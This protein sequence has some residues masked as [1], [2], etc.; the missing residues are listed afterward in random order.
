M[1]LRIPVVLIFRDP[2]H[3]QEQHQYAQLHF[4]EKI[5]Q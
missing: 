2:L 1:I 5:I 4:S 3:Q